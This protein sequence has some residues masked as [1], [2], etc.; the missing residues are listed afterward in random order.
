MVG[1]SCISSVYL[2][3]VFG[4]THLASTLPARS[5]VHLELALSVLDYLHPGSTFFLRSSTQLA[6]AMPIIQSGKIGPVTPILDTIQMES[7]AF[8]QS[9]ACLDSASFALNVAAMDS[10]MS[11]QG[12]T[13]PA[14]TTLI[15][16][17]NQLGSMYALFLID[18]T[19]LGSFLFVQSRVRPGPCMSPLGTAYMGPLP[20]P[21]SFAR[22]GSPAFAFSF[23]QVGLSLSSQKS[24]RV[25]FL[26]FVYRFTTFDF[27]L[28]I[29]DFAHS[30]LSVLSHGVAQLGL[31][32]SMLDATYIDLLMPLQQLIHLG[33][34]VSMFGLN[35]I[36]SLFVL[37]VADYACCGS[38][39]FVRSFAQPGL[40]L[41][42]PDSTK[43]GFSTSLQNVA[44]SE[45]CSPAFGV[46]K[47]DYAQLMS[48]VNYV[49]MGSLVLL[50]SFAHIGSAASVLDLVKVG[51][52]LSLQGLG[53]AA[54][55]MLTIGMARCD[56]SLSIFGAIPVE[57]LPSLR[58]LACLES[59]VSAIFVG[60]P[61]SSMFLRSFSKAD[62]MMLAPG[63]AR[64]ELVSLLPVMESTTL[65][66]PSLVHG[67]TCC[68]SAVLVLDFLHLDFASSVRSMV[69]TGLAQLIFGLSRLGLLSSPSLISSS[70][71]DFLV[72]L[73][74]FAYLEF[75][76]SAPRPTEMGLVLLLHN[77][78][79]SGPAPLVSGRTW[80]GSPS[81]TLDFA[82][83]ELFLSLQSFVQLDPAP[84]AIEMTNLDLSTFAKSL[85]CLGLLV[86]VLGSTCLGLCSLPSVI[87]AC[88]LGL[89][90]LIQDLTRCEPAL[91][92]FDF[93]HLG[94]LLS[95]R[96]L[97]RAA[98]ILLVA[99]ISRIDSVSSLLLTDAGFLGLLMLLQSFS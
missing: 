98:L 58:S 91:L 8:A 16:G 22:L 41:S 5:L 19:Y 36:D 13:Q 64:L 96:S 7:I 94:F 81:P 79:R 6:P 61:G 32:L 33:S 43:C 40:T 2:L 28:L 26:L 45:L 27:L 11:I 35:R 3:P 37:P 12:F 48:V 39:T 65:G 78:A 20:S 92:V 46:C 21:R 72:F 52:A 77:A 9:F 59:P 56:F 31:L 80:G 63:I 53:R 82:T 62:P 66:S 95:L 83:P 69:C 30:G 99:G 15:P 89:F 86:F 25:E 84:L 73:R 75:V 42:V 68:D 67:S 88:H 23:P 34:A 44:Q 85:S 97:S 93:L 10:S 1:I 38:S 74:S 87:D 55:S 14:S 24:A 50:R 54:P 51:L 4:F 60:H 18:V 49:I 71:L 90:L 76:L 47:F 70:Y 57:S 29:F 17:I